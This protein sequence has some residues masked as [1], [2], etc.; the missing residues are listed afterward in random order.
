MDKLL[1]QC[2][3]GVGH[4][5]EIRAEVDGGFSIHSNFHSRAQ[6]EQLRDWLN[7]YLSQPTPEE[8]A[9]AESLRAEWAGDAPTTA[10]ETWHAGHQRDWIR[11][12][13]AA[14]KRGAKC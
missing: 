2:T 11:V 4:I 10:F 7:E 5:T 3:S 9:M 1:M 12:A 6:A 13:R 14:M 8:I